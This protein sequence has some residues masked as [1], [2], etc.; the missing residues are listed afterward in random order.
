MQQQGSLHYQESTKSKAPETSHAKQQEPQKY[1]PISRI[2]SSNWVTPASSVGNP[3]PPGSALILVDWIRD[4]DSERAKI[5]HK[6][7]KKF[8]IL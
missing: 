5:T 2:A 4:P 3:D 1:H 7:V 6:I 8:S